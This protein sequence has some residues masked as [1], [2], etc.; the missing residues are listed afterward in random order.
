MLSRKNFLQGG[1][2]SGAALLLSSPSALARTG[3][4]SNRNDAMQLTEA[5]D[6]TFPA[7]TRSTTGR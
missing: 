6:K 2:V 7:A 5:W 1:V 3:P 4:A